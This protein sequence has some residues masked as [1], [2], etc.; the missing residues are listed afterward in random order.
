MENKKATE[1]K[2]PTCKESKQVKITQ[3]L[4]FILGGIMTFLSIYGLISMIKDIKSL[5]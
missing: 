3:R 1:V 5:F 4:V 2:C